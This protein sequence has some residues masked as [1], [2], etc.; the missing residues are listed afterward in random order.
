[1]QKRLITTL[2]A[3]VY[4]IFAFAAVGCGPSPDVDAPA[5]GPAAQDE[6]T[7]DQIE[8]G[9]GPITEVVLEAVDPSLAATGAELYTLKCSSCHKLD[10]R[11]IGPALADVTLRRTPEFVMNMMLNPEEMT[12]RHPEGKK[13][14]AEY[15]APMANQSLTTDEARAILEYLRS[16]AKELDL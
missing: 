6:L 5:P 8:N 15:I 14:L 1:V 9:I 12:Q 7:A 2:F 10:S 4:L 3:S 11:Y 16:E 13:L